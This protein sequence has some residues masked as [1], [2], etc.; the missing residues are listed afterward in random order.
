[1]GDG[2]NHVR[3]GDSIVIRSSV[4]NAMLDAAKATQARRNAIG[5][6]TS[7]SR[8]TPIMIRIDSGGNLSQYEI[9]GISGMVF[10]PADDGF[11]PRIILTGDTPATGSHEGKFAVLTSSLPDGDMG[12]AVVDG[13]TLCQ[14]NIMDADHEY[15]DITNADSAKLT[16]AAIGP[17]Q[18][19]W[20][21][22]GTGTKWAVVRLS[23]KADS[24][25][26][27]G[28]D[29][30]KVMVSAND[31]TPDYLENKI[32]TSDAWLGDTTLNDGADEDVNLVHNIPPDATP[33]F[34]PI[35]TDG[36]DTLCSPRAVCDDRGHVLGWMGLSGGVYST[37]AWYSPWGYSAPSL[38]LNGSH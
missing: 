12:P 10:A 9:L 35:D 29:D 27:P 2:L 36:Y 28:V 15:A 38:P 33:A 22:T 8:G 37:S 14:V 21:E 31:T 3:A 23:T 4:W 13:V 20:A 5:R 18:I 16:S 6:P 34:S 26:S 1:M 25:G 19:I 30:H 7:P 17:A 24:A 32:T 11:K